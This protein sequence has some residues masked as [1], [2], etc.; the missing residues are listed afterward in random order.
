MSTC[1]PTQNLSIEHT[2]LRVVQQSR[3]SRSTL[4]VANGGFSGSLIRGFISRLLQRYS[5]RRQQKID[6]DAFLTMLSLDDKLLD[7]IGVTRAD[8]T[9]AANLPLSDDA[10]TVL[11]QC[12]KGSR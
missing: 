1:C 4:Q 10:A 5:L 12:T 11:R 2:Q 7:D 6:R 9:W 8:V 3:S